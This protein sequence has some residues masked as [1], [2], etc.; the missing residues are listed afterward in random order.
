VADQQDLVPLGNCCNGTTQASAQEARAARTAA[1]EG[2]Q[3]LSSAFAAAGEGL[4]PLGNCC[5]GTSQE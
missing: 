4:Q 3:V 5:N 2:V 1:P